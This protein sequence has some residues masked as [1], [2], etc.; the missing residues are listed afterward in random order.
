MLSTIRRWILP[1][2]AILLS[3]AC[4]SDSEERNISTTEPPS[5]GQEFVRESLSLR[6]T[7]QAVQSLYG[8]RGAGPV[9]VSATLSS[10]LPLEATTL[11][12]RVFESEGFHDVVLR[13]VPE[14][15]G[16]SGRGSRLDATSEAYVG[17]HELCFDFAAVHEEGI[18]VLQVDVSATDPVV[19]R[20][21]GVN[22]Q[23]L[24]TFPVDPAQPCLCLDEMNGVRRMESSM[25]G[26]GGISDIVI[27]PSPGRGQKGRVAGDTVF[28]DLDESGSRDPGEPGVA[29]VR[30][31]GIHVGRD[32]VSGTR[33][34]VVATTWTDKEGHYQLRGLPHGRNTILLDKSTAPPD[35]FLVGQSSYTFD[36]DEDQVFHRADFRFVERFGPDD[37]GAIGDRVFLDLNRNG[38]EDE[39]EPG[40]AD[41]TVILRWY[42][43]DGLP[44]TEDDRV[45]ARRSDANGDYLFPTKPP[46][47]FHIHVVEETAPEGVELGTCPPDFE[48]TLTAGSSFL[49]ADFCFQPVA[50]DSGQ[51]SG[52]VFVDENLDT[53]R[54]PNE[55]G[56]PRVGVRIRLAGPDG[57]L[58]TEDDEIRETV[59]DDDGAYHFTNLPVGDTETWVDPQTV[60]N[61]YDPGFCPETQLHFVGEGDH[62]MAVDFC[63]VDPPEPNI[64][65]GRVFCDLNRDGIWDANEPGVPDVRIVLTCAGDDE[66]LGTDDDTETDTLSDENGFYDFEDLTEG[67]CRV[68]LDVDSIP[69]DK[70]PGVCP[71]TVFVTVVD[72]EDF[73]AP[74]FC[75]VPVILDPG[76]VRG[77]V[78][79][80]DNDNMRQDGREPR[81]PGISIRLV[82]V[83]ADGEFSTFDDVVFSQVTASEGAYEFPF[84]PTGDY[85][86]WVD[87]STVPRSKSRAGCDVRAEL[88][89]FPND[90]YER[91]FCFASCNECRNYVSTLTLRYDGP[92]DAMVRVRQHNNYTVFHDTVSPGEEFSF[93]GGFR[94]SFGPSVKI[95]VDG[96]PN[97][98]IDT[99]CDVPVGPGQVFGDFVIMAGESK[100]GGPLC[101]VE[102]MRPAVQPQ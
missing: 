50:P 46:G 102:P 31:R 74:N 66:I 14:E 5:A 89:I 86:L 9:L 15:S 25:S 64:I 96:G 59:T 26:A 16:E 3:T 17:P 29:G 30:I 92:A 87:E 56:I 45:S 62:I 19:L 95:S 33:D 72:G 23:L 47:N 57:E 88:V 81:M 94:G 60:P 49:D 101:P 10:A 63:Y 39:S 4:G 97:L 28:L 61:E 53:T 37:E 43:L 98:V 48:F 52:T 84:L 80:D 76:L 27:V 21:F 2:V 75:V 12:V 13:A 54:D 34:D 70:L 99:S 71:A 100:L 91:D 78:F 11:P 8:E 68:D 82:F 69:E 44:N 83:G 67:E 36:F 32:G 1:V 73:V 7:N 65:P 93:V 35:L 55:P 40:I 18:S 42:G 77:I 38:V 20:F 22:D 79:C 51:L 85:Q 24:G 41:V 58:G 6:V 90:V